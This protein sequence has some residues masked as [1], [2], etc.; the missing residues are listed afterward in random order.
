M[1]VPTTEAEKTIPENPKSESAQPETRIR[2]VKLIFMSRNAV[3]ATSVFSIPPHR[4]I[5]VGVWM[6][7]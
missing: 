7:I 1:T 4:V 5:E 3:N 2:L 6:A